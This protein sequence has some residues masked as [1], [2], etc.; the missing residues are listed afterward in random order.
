MEIT[1]PNLDPG[2]TD[3]TTGRSLTTAGFE[4]NLN[5]VK[6]EQVIYDARPQPK[7]PGFFSGLL[8]ALG[9]F[10]PLAYLAAP[11]TGGLS[12][13]AG[14]GLQSMGAIGAKSQAN[15]Q[16]QQANNQQ[17]PVT[18][19]YPGM[20]SASLASDPTMAVVSS[21]DASMTQAIQSF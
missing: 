2:Q 12:L 13:I 5:R 6:F 9:G 18:V 8:R 14:A 16:A 15:F 10:A 3:P 19:S 11:F 20:M 17:Q 7:K 1:T 4:N 21:R